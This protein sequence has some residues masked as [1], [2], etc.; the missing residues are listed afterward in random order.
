MA[1]SIHPQIT[2]N[3]PSLTG[4]EELGCWAV[5]LNHSNKNNCS[6]QVPPRGAKYSPRGRRSQV[7]HPQKQCVTTATKTDLFQQALGRSYISVRPMSP[8]LGPRHREPSCYLMFT[9]KQLAG[10]ISACK[11]NDLFP[12]K[13]AGSQRHILIPLPARVTWGLPALTFDKKG[14]LQLPAACQHQTVTFQTTVNFTDL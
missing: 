3:D 10:Q 13:P 9:K 2:H 5:A 14:R 6:E 11:W 1:S 12:R 7:C 4:R 8:A